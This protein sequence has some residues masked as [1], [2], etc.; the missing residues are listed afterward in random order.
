MA[1]KG[2]GALLVMD[3][4]KPVELFDDLPSSI[5]LRA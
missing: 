5:T 1:D 4:D 2:V 3:G